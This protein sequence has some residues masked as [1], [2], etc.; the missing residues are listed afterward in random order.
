MF[1]VVDDVCKVMVFFFKMYFDYMDEKI[2][3][4]GVIG[5]NGKI[6][7]VVYVRLFLIFLKLLIGLIGM[8]GIWLLKKKLVYKKS[9][10]II[11]ELVD[12]YKIFYDLYIRGDEVV[13]MEVFLIVID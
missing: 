10:F 9:M 4:I 12:L 6:I 1:L 8:I 13:V 5:I 3:I 11:F 7:V 2:E